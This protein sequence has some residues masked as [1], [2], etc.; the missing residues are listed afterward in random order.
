MSKL[1][2]LSGKVAI[3]TGASRGLGQY[4]SRALALAGADLVITSRTIDSLTDFAHEIESYGRKVLPVALDVTDH[5]SIRNAV[6]AVIARFGKIDILVNNAGMNKRKYAIDYSW[7]EWNMIVD[8]NLRGSFFMAQEVAKTMIPNRYGRIINIGSGTSIF[9]YKTVSAY[10]A[11]RGGIKQMTMCMAAEWAEYNINVNC[12]APGWFRTEIN[13]KQFDDTVWTE[14][15]TERIPA[16]RFG[17]EHDLDTTVLYFASE[18]SKYVTG[19]II[20]VDG[21]FSTGDVA[22][23]ASVAPP[24]LQ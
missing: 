15:V 6:A 3:V 5:A 2:D 4:M 16:R 9:G 24:S 12:L 13:A 23:P 7:E 8:T 20:C 18:A 10:S 14:K 11:S 21:G 22:V 17:Q 19:Q 1:F